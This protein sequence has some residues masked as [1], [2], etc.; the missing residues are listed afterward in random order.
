M[1]SACARLLATMRWSPPARLRAGLLRNALGVV[2]LAT[3][4]AMTTGA[5]A[6]ALA[7]SQSDVLWSTAPTGSLF[8]DGG[9]VVNNNVNCS[10]VIGSA[11]ART[12]ISN[13]EADL[14]PQNGVFIFGAP[15]TACR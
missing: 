13:V 7:C 8:V 12:T 6:D 5:A 3:L 4:C 1:P 14:D 11:G 15:I 2:V 10:F 9:A